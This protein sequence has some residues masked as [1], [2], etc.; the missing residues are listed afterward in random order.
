[1]L[2]RAW[3]GSPLDRVRSINKE[4]VT[5]FGRRLSMHLMAQQSVASRLLQNV[6]YRQQGFLARWLIA[7]PDSI[8]GTRQFDP[9]A[10]AADSDLRLA[11]YNQAIK[12]LITRRIAESIDV[13]GLELPV[14]ELSRR[15]KAILTRFYDEFESAQRSGGSLEQGREWASKAAEHACRVAGVLALV[16]DSDAKTVKAAVM[17]RG[18]KL[19]R[20]Y[21]SE[22]LRLVGGASV[23]VEMEQAEL[24]RGWLTSR[25]RTEVTVRYIV[26]RG[27]AWIREAKK[28]RAVLATLA[29]F[30][31]V[32]QEGSR[33]L[34]HPELLKNAT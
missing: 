14:L 5:L 21:M 8:V 22:Y 19:V 10:P 13:G 33:Y 20:H 25:H 32:R 29:E 30:G 18:V 28:A 26:Q 17:R 15:A 6:L 34:L 4:N 1:M 3:D 9:D 11:S 2:S 31:W 16:G 24:L 7:A 27:P 12:R 23:S